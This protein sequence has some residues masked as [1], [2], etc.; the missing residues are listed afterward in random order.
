[1]PGIASHAFVRIAERLEFQAVRIQ[2]DR[3]T[4]DDEEITIARDE[5]RHRSS[6]PGVAVQPKPTGHRVRHP[7]PTVVELPP[8]SLAQLEWARY[9]QPMSPS[10]DAGACAVTLPTKI[11]H[12]SGYACGW[13]AV[14]AQPEAVALVMF[15]TTPGELW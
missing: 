7:L 11:A 9:W 6:H 14:A 1:V 3:T 12:V 2:P 4:V 5:M 15:R 8:A 10:T 13:V